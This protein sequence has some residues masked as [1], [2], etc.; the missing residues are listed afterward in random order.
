MQ[1]RNNYDVVWVSASGQPGTGVFNGD[2]GVII[3]IDLVNELLRVDFEDKIAVY[4]FE[5]LNE[6]EHAWAMT[7]HKSQGSEYRAVILALNS[8]SP[9]LMT[10]GV[11]YTALTRAKELL[12]MVGDEAIAH[13]MIDNHR[14]SR[15]YSALRI[16]LVGENL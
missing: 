3:D 13:S 16:R 15:R 1:I 10:R 6:L 14:Q 7:V 9:M 2:V 12:I 4:G 11:L 5:L 8:G